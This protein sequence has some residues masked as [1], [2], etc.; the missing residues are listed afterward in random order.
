[1]PVA[2]VF[3]PATGFSFLHSDGG[4]LGGCDRR[5]RVPAELRKQRQRRRDV[6]N[7]AELARAVNAEVV[8]DRRCGE[9]VVSGKVVNRC[10]EHAAI[11]RVPFEHAV[12][13]GVAL[14]VEGDAVNL[15]V[16]AATQQGR[17]DL[18]GFDEFEVE[19]HR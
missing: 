14:L 15:V 2:G 13:R 9:G 8:H 5:Q 16:A 1:L 12:G 3:S 17:A 7:A 10:A 6:G 19:R 18:V 11:A 4:S